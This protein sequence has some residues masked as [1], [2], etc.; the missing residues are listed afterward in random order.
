MLSGRLMK[1]YSLMPHF[2]VVLPPSATSTV[3]MPSGSTRIISPRSFAVIITALPGSETSA[4]KLWYMPLR[5][6]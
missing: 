2:M 6:S 3:T 5:R 1:E 4:S